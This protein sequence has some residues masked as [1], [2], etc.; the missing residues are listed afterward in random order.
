MLSFV[1]AVL[2]KLRITMRAVRVCVVR[3]SVTAE[4]SIALTHI[5]HHVQQLIGN[6]SYDGEKGSDLASAL[7]V[8]GSQAFIGARSGAWRVVVVVTGHLLASSQLNAAVDDLTSA[9]IELI[10]VAVTG[11]GGVEVDTLRKISSETRRVDDYDKLS[12]KTDEVVQYICDGRHSRGLQ[13]P[14]ARGKSS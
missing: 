13:I 9:D 12:D 8:T 14:A 2:D 5:D 3:Y 11:Y 10:V 4:L 6:L 7:A 1:Q